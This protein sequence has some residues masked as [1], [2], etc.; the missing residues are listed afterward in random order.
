M[1]HLFL[2]Y[3]LALLAKEKGF[4]ERCL[5]GYIDSLTF[6]LYK[7]PDM[8]GWCNRNCSG[9]EITAPLYQQII[10][11]FREKHNL[12]I[13]VFQSGDTE[14]DYTF[15]IFECKYPQATVGRGSS[16]SYYEELNKGIEEA[17]KLIK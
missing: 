8:S 13:S 16:S 14:D 9:G 15:R 7:D 3:E 4:D 10:D 17:F 11:W 6:Q 5:A 2:P 12:F 1:K